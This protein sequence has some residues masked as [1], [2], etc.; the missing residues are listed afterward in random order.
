MKWYIKL[1]TARN[2]TVYITAEALAPSAVLGVLYDVYN[3]IVAIGPDGK[4]KWIS[5]LSTYKER[6]WQYIVEGKKAMYLVL[7][8]KK[9]ISFFKH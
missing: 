4:I 5:E 7:K 8:D 2:G 1:I 9:E 6:K 3:V